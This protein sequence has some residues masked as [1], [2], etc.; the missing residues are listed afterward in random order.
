MSEWEEVELGD[1][2]E[3]KRG[4]D[5]PTK[6]RTP[7][8]YPIV[9]SSGITGD[10]NEA[11]VKG[12]GVVT[13][14]YGTLGEVFFIKSDFWPLNTALYVKDFKGNDPRFVSYLLQTLELEAQNAAGAVPGVNRN[15]LHRMSVEIPPLDTQKKISSILASYDD[16]IEINMDRIGILEEM[17]TVL[18]YEWFREYRFPGH[19]DIET[20]ESEIGRIPKNWDVKPFSEVVDIKPRER[21]DKD[22]TKP[23]VPMGSV[24]TDSM[25]IEPIEER[26]GNRGAKFR[27]NDTV[28][29][30][31]TPSLENGKTGFVRFMSSDEQIALGSGELIPFRSRDLCPELVY[32]IARD[33]DFRQNAIKSMTGASGRQRVQTECFDDYLLAVPPQE[34][35]DHFQEHV[36]PM[37]DLVFNLA[38][39]NQCLKQIRDV[40]IPRLFS[41]RL[42][43]SGL[44]IDW[45]AYMT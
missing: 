40:L 45:E 6:D 15:H 12:P 27:N 42:D 38:E 31:I 21:P 33:E 36:G 11:K 24:S 14:R 41:R 26:D 35:L 10:H 9:S 4:Y 22:R 13:G 29:A 7:G 32:L 43:V 44:E 23:Y 28:F 18:Y 2:V 25:V 30:R 37:F 1:V 16:L 39:R 8:E 20:V 19:D 3:L 17:V 34:V 5:L